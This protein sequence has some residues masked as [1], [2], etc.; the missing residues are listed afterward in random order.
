[1]VCTTYLTYG[2]LGI[3]S[4][5]LGSTLSTLSTLSTPSTPSTIRIY[6]IIYTI[7]YNIIVKEYRIVSTRDLREKWR[8]WR[9]RKLRESWNKT[10]VGN[11][12]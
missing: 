4:S 7:T 3:P 2:E 9:V 11:P 12:R 8:V 1:M 5:H 6:T 10:L